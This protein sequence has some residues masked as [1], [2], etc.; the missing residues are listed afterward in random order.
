MP[1]P[2]GCD[3]AFHHGLVDW[4]GA[5]KDGV[6]FAFI[7]WGQRREWHDSQAKA[8]WHNSKGVVWRGAYWV[9]DERDGDGA[10]THELGVEE[11]MRDIGI[12]T[13]DGEL[14][15]VVDLELEPVS[16]D[17]LSWFLYWIEAWIKRKPIIYTGSWFYSRVKPIPDW[18]ANYE[19]WLTGY[20]EDG[21]RIWGAL[22]ELDPPVVCWQQANNWQID[23]T[24]KRKIVDRDYWWAGLAHLLEIANMA[25][26]VVKVADLLKWIKENQY[27]A[28]AVPGGPIP[29]KL[30]WPAPPPVVVTQ[31]YGVNPQF[32]PGQKGHEGIDIRATNGTPIMAGA[33]GTVYRTEDDAD[34]GPYGKHVRIEHPHSDGPFKTVYAHLQQIIVNEGEDVIAGQTIGAADNTGNS[35]GA[36]LHLTLKKVGD[37]S[38]WLQ[39]DDIV[40]PTPYL[41]AIF[42]GTT[43]W[44]VNVAGNLRTVPIV[45][46]DSLIRLVRVGELVHPTGIFT[47]DW[48]ELNIAGT[49]GWFWEPGYKLQMQ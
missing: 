27:D 34:S 37:G 25:D 35:S 26:K 49:I 13:Y 36:H 40:N 3:T 44:F 22:A 14:P 45:A 48:W 46:S 20:N 30:Q 2:L 7:R 23:W 17:E 5:R 6:V 12:V 24:E 9:W 41:P 39:M 47:G 31:P 29:F 38:D 1:L 15:F 28:S 4:K 32:Y 16:W 18:L 8:S 43:P 10:R 19:H 33:N 11:V 42:P 21:P